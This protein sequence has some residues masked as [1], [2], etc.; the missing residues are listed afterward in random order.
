MRPILVRWRQLL[1]NATGREMYSKSWVLNFTPLARGG[2]SAIVY[3]A[4]IAPFA[5][6]RM[7]SQR[8]SNSQDKA[9]SENAVKKKPKH[10]WRVEVV[11][12]L[13]KFRFFP[14][15]FSHVNCAG[16]TELLQIT[17]HGIGEN[18]YFWPIV[19]SNFLPV[20]EAKSYLS[21]GRTHITW[22]KTRWMFFR[23]LYTELKRFICPFFFCGTVPSRHTPWIGTFR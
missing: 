2:L 9:A 12:D 6:P 8:L 18:F 3:T 15:H 11:V 13:T 23:V 5:M 1:F 4:A 17:L 21:S 20:S 16:L 14:F 10:F 22:E 7:I 19:V